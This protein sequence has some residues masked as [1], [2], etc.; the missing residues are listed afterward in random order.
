MATGRPIDESYWVVEGRLLAGHYPG[1]WD[2]EQAHTKL[3]RFLGAG[4][5][6]FIDLTEPKETLRGKAIVPYDALLQTVASALGRSVEHRRL[7][8]RDVSVPAPS[9][10]RAILDAVDAAIAARR[11]VY[12]HCLG[13]TGRT[14]TVVCCYLVRHGMSGEQALARVAELIR[15]TPKAHRPSPDTPEQCAFVSR[16][17]G[18]D[19]VVADP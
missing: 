1:H 19:R 12:V 11:K 5:D 6:V 2:E 16:W 13:G 9:H 17:A 15:Q 10:M 7:S 4:F 8:I 18:E 3:R 14:G